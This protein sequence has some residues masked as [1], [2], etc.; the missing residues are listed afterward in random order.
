MH[1]RLCIF[2]VDYGDSMAMFQLYVANGITGVRDMGSTVEQ[3][4]EGRKRIQALGVVAPR[5]FASG[6]L[7]DARA[8]NPRS[9]NTTIQ[10]PTPQVGRLVVDLLKEA[11]MDLVKMHGN[12]SPGSLCCDCRKVPGS[13]DTTG[14]PRATGGDHRRGVG[15]RAGSVLNTWAH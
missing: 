1:M 4:V 2:G 15:R 10:V 3:L 12:F 13:A 8:P 5:I 11:G 6:P 9:L 14:R 7:L